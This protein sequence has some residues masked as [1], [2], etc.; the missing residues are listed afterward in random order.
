MTPRSFVRIGAALAA[1]ALVLAACALIPD[2]NIGDVFGMDDAP[3]TLEEQAGGLGTAQFTDCP[4]AGGSHCATFGPTTFADPDIS[5]LA[6]SIIAGF[7]V[8]AGIQATITATGATAPQ[9]TASSFGVSL[10]VSDDDTQDPVSAAASV[11]ASPPVVFE[12]TT[13]DGVYVATDVSDLQLAVAFDG[14][15]LGT[16]KDIL[17]GGGD[18]VA[19]GVVYLDVA[20]DGIA[21][22]TITLESDGATVSF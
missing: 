19:S 20:E 10:T 5:G 7:D 2:Q 1:L 16:L 6:T 18:N 15:E 13:T 9:I 14:S 17:T 4:G 22:M 12:A 3:V 21:T 11:T 8:D